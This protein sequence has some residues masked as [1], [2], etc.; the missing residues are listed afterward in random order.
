MA[1]SCSDWKV[2]DFLCPFYSQMAPKRSVDLMGAE[3]HRP[4]QISSSSNG[5]IYVLIKQ[6]R[7]THI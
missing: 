7:L 3:L 2:A 6:I 1:K 5:S 4:S